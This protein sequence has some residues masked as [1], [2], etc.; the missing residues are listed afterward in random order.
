MAHRILIIRVDNERIHFN[1]ELAISIQA[2]N[3]PQK[4][5][6][7]SSRKSIY[8]KVEMLEYN[9]EGRRLKVAVLDYAFGETQQFIEQKPKKQVAQIL[10]EK[11]DWKKLEPL[12]I[13]YKS[14]ALKEVLINLNTDPFSVDSSGSIETENKFH[15]TSRNEEYEWDVDDP[16]IHGQKALQ[17]IVIEERFTMPFTKVKFV[18]GSVRCSKHISKLDQVIDFEILNENLLPEF[19][20]IKNWFS[21]KLK[22]KKISVTVKIVV[23][24][25]EVIEQK[26]TSKQIDRINSELID[27]VKHQRTLA[28]VRD[29]RI[30]DLDKSLFTAEEIFNQVNTNDIEGNVFAQSELD[31]LNILM[32]QENVRN[33]KHLAYL[34]GKKQS[35]DHKLRY[36]LFPDFGFLFLIEGETSNHF[37]WELLQSHATFIWSLER[38]NGKIARQYKRVEGF[39]NFVRLHGREHYKRGNRQGDLDSDIVF[40]VI[41]HDKIGSDLVDDFPI[42]RARLNEQ[43]T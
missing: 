17:T 28:L 18:L 7:F 38:G 26:A 30:S 25:G 43:I 6:T 33:K 34:S 37:V 5:L 3:I 24:D 4:H 22:T 8:W 10:F 21:K 12:L 29:P 23:K 41:K 27:G 11:F 19:E 31:V 32:N 42:W 2:S 40:R 20:N 14:S 15:N 35:V 9:A 16:N 36:T 39:I 13:H 1:P